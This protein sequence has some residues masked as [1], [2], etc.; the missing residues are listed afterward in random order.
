[1]RVFVTGASGWIGSAV[2]PELLTHGHQVLGLARSDAAAAALTEAGA[3]VVRGSL[4]DL[5]VL[6][7]AAADADGVVHLAFR[8]DLM[9]GGDVQGAV[10]A[11]RKA[12][13][14]M[15]EALVGTGRPLV[16]TGGTPAIPGHVA[17]EADGRVSADAPSAADN[18]AAR[19]A[20]DEMV[21][22]LADE[23]VRSAVVRLPRTNH[24]EGDAGFIA[25][26]IATARDRGVSA[27]VGDGSQRWPATHRLDT[28]RV[29]RLAVEKAPAG[30]VLH[31]VGEEG[32]A[33]RDVAEVIG[34]HLDVP[35]ASVAPEDAMA[36]FG[37]LGAIIS[38][39]QPASGAHTQEL[40][41]WRP[42]EP[43]LLADIEQGHYFRVPTA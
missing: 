25:M 2:V 17:T 35:V 37:W 14:A 8:H 15:A 10:D 43:T 4:D 34:R 26:M 3:E 1:M 30:S 31:A 41:G 28:A 6:R 12:V 24:G 16:H 27:C 7:A 19:A 13:S 38:V 42:T 29:F 5:A 22:A 11:D 32:V 36:H 20:T 33:M 40:L 18:P 23:G 21:L 39:D 9:F